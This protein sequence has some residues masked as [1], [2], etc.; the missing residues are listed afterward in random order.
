MAARATVTGS[1]VIDGLKELVKATKADALIG[2]PMHDA[3][4]KA[5]EITAS[6]VRK[7][8]PVLTGK[9]RD[10]VRW[11]VSA[12]PIPRY[13]S[14]RA[15]ASRRRFRYGWALEQSQRIPFR[16]RSGG[17]S[18]KPTRHWFSGALGIVSN[19][20]QNL[21]ESAEAEVERLWRQR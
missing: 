3:L 5:A 12:A 7:R 10:S 15:N 18:G 20:I 19:Q 13:A 1:I 16:Y 8:A 11:R 14:V 2:K 4:T 9:L 6:E 21:L 17:Q